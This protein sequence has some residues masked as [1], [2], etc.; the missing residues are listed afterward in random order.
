M[1]KSARLSSELGPP[2]SFGAI[3][4]P[5]SVSRRQHTQSKRH[6]RPSSSLSGRLK[7]L[8]SLGVFVFVASACYQLLV[9]PSFFYQGLGPLVVRPSWL[10]LVAFALLP[11]LGL[12]SNIT[13]PSDF[14]MT[15][16]YIIGVLMPALFGA[17]REG[18]IGVDGAFYY[19]LSVVPLFAVANFVRLSVPIRGVKNLPHF[20]RSVLLAVLVGHSIIAIVVVG[21]TFGLR[22]NPFVI[23]DIY[24]TRL[25][26]REI[27]ATSFWATPYLI[28]WQA[29]AINPAIV[30][31][32]L[33]S[34]KK[35]W[36]VPAFL[37]QLAM[38][39]TTAQKSML[40]ALPLVIMVHH[41]VRRR[42]ATRR[43]IDSLTVGVLA[44]AAL[45]ALL[46]SIL[47]TSLATRRALVI[48]GFLAGVYVDYYQPS[49][50][51]PY[52]WAHSMLGAVLGTPDGLAPSREIGRFVSGGDDLAANA[53]T[54]ADGY[55]NGRFLGMI[56]VTVVLVGL[57][58]FVDS[59]ST[60][61]PL[62][63]SASLLTLPSIA[64]ASGS[65]VT[66]FGEHGLGLALLLIA[67]W[68]TQWHER[69]SVQS[70]S[71]P[72]SLGSSMRRSGPICGADS[73]DCAAQPMVR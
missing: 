35:Q 54:W 71:R 40:L 31:Y 23:T 60:R 64:L 69:P 62:G 73:T 44:A 53:G 32:A 52:W 15:F 25:A 43:V 59:I 68:P 50:N 10:A 22:V 17:G 1:T 63:V 51:A 33:E 48:P 34:G 16:L 49:V 12:R 6:L 56:A 3:S 47:A 18:Q 14:L 30:L 67:F 21:L 57:C 5:Q 28:A 26:G 72:S 58:I 66:V 8:V 9:A 27:F 24:D 61:V 41:V 70:T 13:R 46:G 2:S 38:F 65:I 39:T 29:R 42:D 45:D 7:L 36:L 19:T 37:L 20:S 4:R 55:A 11:S